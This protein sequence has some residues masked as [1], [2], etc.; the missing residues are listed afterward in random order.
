MMLPPRW[1]VGLAEK[2]AQV[3]LIAQP[4]LKPAVG[5]SD[6]EREAALMPDTVKRLAFG[7]SRDQCNQVRRSDAGVSNEMAPENGKGP[8]AALVTVAVRAKKRTRLTSR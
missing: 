7:D 1:W 8:P 3:G 2:T 5:C 4:A 6:G